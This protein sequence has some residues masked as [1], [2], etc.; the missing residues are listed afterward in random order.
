MKTRILCIL[1]AF[2]LISLPICSATPGTQV[3][4]FNFY[5]GGSAVQ[6]V[7]NPPQSMIATIGSQYVGQGE[8][9]IVIT[10]VNPE[11]ANITWSLWSGLVNTAIT[12]QSDLG[13]VNRR[14]PTLGR[15]V[16]WPSG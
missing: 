12:G 9:Q 7:P 10:V 8:A 5:L 11:G 4:L 3:T 6:V 16:Q 14:E 2:A 15:L 13:L 1:V